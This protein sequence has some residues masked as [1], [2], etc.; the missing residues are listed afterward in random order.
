MSGRATVISV[1]ARPMLNSNTPPGADVIEFGADVLLVFVGHAENAVAES[2]AIKSLE[3]DFQRL[4]D[5][6]IEV[7]RE[8]PFSRVKVWEWEDDAKAAP[9]GQAGLIAPYLD[10]AQ[11]AIFV[12]R[13]RIGT[14]TWQELERFCKQP[15]AKPVLVLFCADLASTRA[16]TTSML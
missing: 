5:Q 10:R 13:Q 4:L 15:N 16:S 3:R 8:P 14:V 11:I 2:T 9:V 7:M 6:R 1:A 12:F